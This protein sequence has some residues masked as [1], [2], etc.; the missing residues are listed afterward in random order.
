MNKMILI[1]TIAFCIVGWAVAFGATELELELDED[2]PIHASKEVYVDKQDDDVNPDTTS[3]VLKSNELLIREKAIQIAEK[4]VNGKVYNFETDED[5]GQVEYELE[6]M[7]D[8]GEVEIE[9]NARSGEI[10]E[11]DYDDFDDDDY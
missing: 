10:I 4:A 3:T 5:D 1:G 8:H 2:T 6:L 11:I 7:T 9:I